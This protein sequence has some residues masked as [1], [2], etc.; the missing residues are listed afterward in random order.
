MST[1]SKTVSK[2]KT[3]EVSK[4]NQVSDESKESKV[5]TK[6]VA[7][8]ASKDS[9][10]ETKTP[11]VVETTETKEQKP[12]KQ[13]ATKVA[14]EETKTEVVS[15]T[16]EVSA[17]DTTPSVT[18][19][20]T[21]RVVSKE[22]LEKEYDDFL[23][24]VSSELEVVKSAGNKYKATRFLKQVIKT[25]KGLKVD[26]LKL[27]KKKGRSG[28]KRENLTSGFMKP[29]SVSSD[30]SKFA[31]WSGEELKSRVD[32]TKFICEYISKNNLQ[33]PQDKRQILP[34]EKLSKLLSFDKNT[35]KDPLTYYGLQKLIQP[36]FSKTVPK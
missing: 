30:M 1:K 7:K 21:K 16:K 25:L 27:C 11:V 18:E 5:E 28:V 2:T 26:S 12:R 34:D 22:S 9:K 13:K 24:T 14:K 3:T 15:E 4:T 29:V 23:T 8:K 6:K 35:S 19:P 32:V 36:H 33:N 20:K 31:G 10:D 17:S